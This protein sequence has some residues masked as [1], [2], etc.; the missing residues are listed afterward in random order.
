MTSPDCEIREARL[1]DVPAMAEVTSTGFMDSELSN[2]LCPKRREYPEDWLY[3]YQKRH[4]GQLANPAFKNFVCV[5]AA[6]ARIAAICHVQRRGTV[7]LARLE[8]DRSD[9]ERAE[10][11]R[12]VEQSRLLDDEAWTDRTVDPAAMAYF[13]ANG[14][15]IKHHF[16][17]EG[18]ECWELTHLCVHP[19]FQGKGYGS[20]L[21]QSVI[22]LATDADPRVPVGLVSSPAGD[23]FYEK[24]GFVQV[25]HAKRA[26]GPMSHLDGG[27][28]KFYDRHLN[29]EAQN[30][31]T[32]LRP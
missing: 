14:E 20:R 8:R 26:N 10:C 27:S 24:R 1:A 29:A 2:Y 5:D 12:A 3:S 23:R 7:G 6:S 32:R 11:A 17:G 22:D 25:G 30:P 13:M 21:L 18:V 4:R 31:G 15:H 19:D 16:T 28:I 9:A